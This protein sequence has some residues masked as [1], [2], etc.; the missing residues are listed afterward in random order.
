MERVRRNDPTA[1]GRSPHVDRSQRL[2]LFVVRLLSE[3]NY[4]PSCFP[5]TIPCY[6]A[7]FFS[8]LI[9]FYYYYCQDTKDANSVRLSYTTVHPFTERSL[10][11][12]TVYVSL[13]Y[14]DDIGHL[15]THLTLFFLYRLFLL[16]SKVSSF[17]YVVYRVIVFL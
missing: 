2:R 14:G 13:C 15:Y 5:N 10:F 9:F 3:T 6:I 11:R 16:C 7:L 8:I 17:Y 1:V 4:D 12:F